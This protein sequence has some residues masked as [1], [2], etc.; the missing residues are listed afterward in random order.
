MCVVTNGWM[1]YLQFYVL[2]TVFQSKNHERLC[3]MDP[4]LRLKIFLPAAGIEP[5]TPRSVGLRL[6]PL[7]SWGTAY[8]CLK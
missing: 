5:G 6:N 4:H 7:S 3:A 1:D 2:F 8:I